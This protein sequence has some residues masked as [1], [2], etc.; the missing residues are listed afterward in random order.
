MY[1]STVMELVNC[2]L[3]QLTDLVGNTGITRLHRIGIDYPGEP[4]NII[5]AETG[6]YP[7]IDQYPAQAFVSRI[8]MEAREISYDK[9]DPLAIV[10]YP[11]IMKQQ[12]TGYP[13]VGET[14]LNIGTL[15]HELT[16]VKQ[17]FSGRLEML[18]WLKVKWEG[19]CHEIEM[20]GYLA[21]PW[22]KEACMEQLEWIT[23]GNTIMAELQYK[24]LVE[25]S[26]LIQA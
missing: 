14:F 17:V 15:L 13:S 24:A 2:T 25:N 9:K 20:S 16:H 26:K 5:F 3:E 19:V 4:L 22:E 12:H 10:F 1:R 18:D 11:A 7:I 21:Y 6:D 23:R 8:D